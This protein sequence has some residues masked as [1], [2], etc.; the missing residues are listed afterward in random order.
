MRRLTVVV[1]CAIGLIPLA[2]CQSDQDPS[3]ELPTTTTSAPAPGASVTTATTIAAGYGTSEISVPRGK[4]TA[5]LRAVRAAH[6]SGFDRVVFEFEGAL[7]GYSVSY[8]QKPVTEDGSGKPVDVAGD[9]VLQVRMDP[10]S[11]ADLSGGNVRQTYTGPTRIKPTTSAVTEVVRT[12]D[13]EAVLTWAIGVK[14]HPGFRVNTSGSKLII[15]IA[16]T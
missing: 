3:L 7:P 15:E 12:G 1:I 2:A 4:T 14:V 8:V 10:A 5:L 11:G 9:A 13:F 16:T 6:Q